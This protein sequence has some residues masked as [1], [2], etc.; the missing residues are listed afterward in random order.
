MKSYDFLEHTADVKFRAYGKSLAEAFSNAAIATTEIM[1]SVDDVKAK[2]LR[3]ISIE[4]KTKE[5]L[6]YDF[7]EKLLYLLDTEAYITG[8]VK[9]LRIKKT[10][11]NTYKL[12][13][14]V[15]G[16]V[17]D[18]YDVHTYI[19]AVTYND[20]FI[21]EKKDKVVVQVVHDI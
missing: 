15:L 19:K 10:K 6:L 8:K 7:L 14:L 18:D 20:M 12:N 5:S 1:T 9:S 16:D 17:A 13:A 3:K 2:K 4:S 21:E 11:K